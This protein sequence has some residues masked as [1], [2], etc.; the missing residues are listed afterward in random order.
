MGEYINMK[1]LRKYPLVRTTPDMEETSKHFA[2]G[3][4]SCL[5]YAEDQKIQADLVDVNKV[6]HIID[7][8]PTDYINKNELIKKIIVL[9]EED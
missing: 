4:Q 9:S 7:H 1:T 8:F 5:E 6:L 2:Y 3:G